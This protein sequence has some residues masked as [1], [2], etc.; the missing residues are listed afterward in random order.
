V[1][2]APPRPPSV[3]ITRDDMP[4]AP[5]GYHASICSIGEETCEPW[6]D[7]IAERWLQWT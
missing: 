5:L 2:G 4:P 6:N 1:F 3:I 7:E